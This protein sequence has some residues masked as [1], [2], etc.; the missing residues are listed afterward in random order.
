MVESLNAT[1]LFGFYRL[2]LN[3]E[4]ILRIIEKRSTSFKIVVFSPRPELERKIIIDFF[5]TF[6]IIKN[7][8]NIVIILNVFKSFSETAIIVCMI[9]D[10]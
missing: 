7:P 3:K 5:K 10:H 1:S 9:F 2:R 6:D 4:L 8:F